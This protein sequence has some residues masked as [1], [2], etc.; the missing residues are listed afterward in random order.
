MIGIGHG[1]PN[2]LFGYLSSTPVPHMKN[3]SGGWGIKQ[4]SPKTGK[5]E[6]TE[7]SR[8]NSSITSIEEIK[9]SQSNSP[10]TNKIGLLRKVLEGIHDENQVLITAKPKNRSTKIRK[11]NRHSRFRGVSLNGK[12]WQVMIMGQIKKK[13]FGGISTEREAA[14]FYDKLSILTNGLAAKTNFNYRKCDLMRI[15]A[16]LEYMESIIS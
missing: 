16:E 4:F 14:I 1:Q 10:T 7:Y 2:Q 11:S 15:M 8:K 12:K 5:Q 3:S 6:S 9:T 13:Y